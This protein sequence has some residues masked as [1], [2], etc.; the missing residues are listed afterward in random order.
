MRF[1]MKAALKALIVNMAVRDFLRPETAH[2]MLV[3]FGLV[4]VRKRKM[5]K[6]GV[7]PL[8]IDWINNANKYSEK[9]GGEAKGDNQ[10]DS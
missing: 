2:R 9:G 6:N 5:D 4:H 10:G 3:R 7:Q 8:K 1:F